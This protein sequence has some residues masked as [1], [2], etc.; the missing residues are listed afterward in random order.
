MKDTSSFSGGRKIHDAFAFVPIECQVK[1]S[2]MP[3]SVHIIFR[4]PYKQKSGIS[5]GLPSETVGQEGGGEF[6]RG[7]PSPEN[8][9]RGNEKGEMKKGK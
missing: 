1:S 8:G 6:H 5:R 4:L 3:P 9:K 2:T 7:M